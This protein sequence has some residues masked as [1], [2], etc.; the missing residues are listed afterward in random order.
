[1][2]Y[3]IVVGELSGDLHGSNLMKGI[4]KHDADAQFAYMG[5]EL[6]QA[7]ADGM[8]RHY[9]ST[10]L[11]GIA[12]VIKNLSVVK[13]ALDQVKN[14][15]DEYQP[16]AIILIDFPSFNM[17]IAEFAKK[18]NL[19]VFYYISP[20]IWAWKTWRIKGIKKYVD[21]MLTIFPF[22]TDF[23]KSY[24]VEVNYVGN[25]LLDSIGEFKSSAISKEQFSSENNLENGKK[26]IALLP[27]SRNHELRLNLRIMLEAVK[28]LTDYQIVIGA[29]HA[30][31][32]DLY[33]KI[34]EGYD[35]K[36]VQDKTYDLLNNAHAALVTSGT[37]TLETGLIGCPQVVLFYMKN[38]WF[39]KYVLKYII[40]VKWVSLVNLILNKEAVREL[41]VHE[42]TVE[43]TRKELTKI[44]DGED[45]KQQ[46]ED[47]KQLNNL[48]LPYGAGDNAGKIIVSSTPHRL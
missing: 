6:M 10:A 33:L 26:I 40:K 44:L 4:I 22:E 18:R 17:K 2:K 38:S 14:G 29:T 36:L 39:F 12:A 21:K 47:Y 8:I 27:G 41:I 31:P 34:A 20:K 46:I 42:C 7:V 35:V 23:Y 13:Q 30:V 25:P 45:R 16:D 11:M 15:I 28:D 3:F 32:N 5:G 9:K 1:M 37:A 24:G 19:K 43:N 48:L